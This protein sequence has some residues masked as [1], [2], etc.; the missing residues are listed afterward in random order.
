MI[1]DPT[2]SIELKIQMLQ[3]YILVNSLAYYE[4]N[5]NIHPDYVYDANA[6]QLAMLM[7]TYPEKALKTRYAACFYDF[8]G[9]DDSSHYVSGFDL[10]Q[11]LRES[12]YDLYECVYSQANAV[13]NIKRRMKNT[14]MRFRR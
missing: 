7:R 12:D 2:W 11:R 8:C 5:E 4:L 1:F 14:T 9:D 10:L 13:L 3:R 6:V